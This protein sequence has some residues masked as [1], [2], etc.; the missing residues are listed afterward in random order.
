MS[1]SDRYASKCRWAFIKGITSLA[2]AIANGIWAIGCPMLAIPAFA[3][4][5]VAAYYLSD[6]KYNFIQYDTAS[7]WEI[8]QSIRPRL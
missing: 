5:Y 4:A 2:I 6:A 3:F 7:K 1:R 8:R